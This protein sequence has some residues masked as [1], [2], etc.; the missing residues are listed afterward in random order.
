MF[1]LAVSMLRWASLIGTNI[2]YSGGPINQTST[3]LKTVVT[4]T[5]IPTQ[6]DSTALN[7]GII[8]AITIPVVVVTFL[9]LLLF[10]VVVLKRKSM[11]ETIARYILEP[12]L[13]VNPYNI[14]NPYLCQ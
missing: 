7:G 14:R 2:F 8:A 11:A 5:V 3:V 9:L 6:R 13:Y 10:V 1:K 12:T 4:F